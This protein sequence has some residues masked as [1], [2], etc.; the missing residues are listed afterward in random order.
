MGE[1]WNLIATRG[2]GPFV[3][4][5]VW[6][7]EGGE[8]VVLDSRCRRKRSPRLNPALR[9]GAHGKRA[10]LWAPRRLTWWISVLFMIGATCFA[11]PSL[12]VF[13]DATSAMTVAVVY[14]AGSLFFTSAGYL[15]LFESINAGRE[16]GPG[17]AQ[18]L[19][20]RLVPLAWQPHRIDYWAT[21]VQFVG[22]LFFNVTTFRALDITLSGR[23]YDYEVWRPNAF[24]SVCF[25]IASYLADA[26]ISHSF[27]H[28][29]VRTLAWWI[30]A[31]NMVG[32]VAFGVSAVSAWELPS[33][34]M[35]FT[36]TARL[37][38]LVGAVCF[39][40]GAFLLL[41]EAAREQPEV[42]ADLVGTCSP[43]HAPAPEEPGCRGSD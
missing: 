24:G 29:R 34:A 43:V 6:R 19:S 41:P 26:E 38:T 9:R 20:H 10:F 23:D 25:L 30:A 18:G 22:T 37:G 39:F 17:A 5:E 11:V 14:L 27:W 3:T 31:A 35:L 12:S 1:R 13:A 7:S 36:D 16:S 4:Q 15:Q 21:L 2:P 32:S 28:Q 8:T 40:A 42:P 33:G